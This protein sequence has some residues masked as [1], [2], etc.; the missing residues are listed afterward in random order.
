MLTFIVRR[1]IASFFIVIGA[2]FIAYMLVSYAGN[3]LTVAYGIQQP[4][5]RA[6]KI[7]Q[8][9]ADLHLNVNPVFRFFIWLK[10]VLACFIGRCDF[11]MTIDGRSVTEDLGNAVL[12]SLRL[13]TAATVAAILIGVSIGIITALRQYSGLDYTVTFLAFLFFSL[14]VFWFGV[15]LKDAVGIQF[16]DFLQKD[17]GAFSWAAIFIVSLVV[18]V[19]AYALFGGEL[20][21]R[22]LTALIAAVVTFGVMYYI[23]VTNWLLD[24]SLGIVM[25]ALI[26]VALGL[27]ITQLTA[28]V[29]NRKALYTSMTTV[30]VGV[31]L[32]Y[33]L[34]YYFYSDFNF[35]KL[36]LLF[37]IA[38]GV[39][40]V[41]GYL[42][43]GDD[44]GLSARTGAFTAVATSVVIFTDRMMRAWHA[45]MANPAINGRPIKLTL[46]GTP[47]LKG[48]FWIQTT[49]VFTHLLL[50]TITLMLV[51]LATHSRF[52]RASMLEVLNQDY[53]RTARSKGLTERTVVMRHAFRNALIPVATVIAFDIAGLV[54]GAVLT[55]TV[56]GWKALG[57][58]FQDGLTNFD[59]NPVMATFLVAAVIAV[60][61]NL[62]ADIAYGALDPR[63]RVKA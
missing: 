10:G 16:N 25:I 29:R 45:Y 59:P 9:T 19:V 22:L 52:A 12:I 37:V 2:S 60:L 14:P 18:G 48:D 32:W 49:D 53:I 54:G 15:L 43:G 27:G 57:K 58:M 55:E 36:M 33:P 28:G 3:P 24:P 11:G 34:Q 35:W 31:A 30:G 46:P 8:I 7:A 23:T 51:S 42:W 1:I 61:A 26:S 44:R 13:I 63:I 38:I 17:D 40:I 6:Q 39:G 20:K 62:L 56:F 21:R 5:A 47:L 4:E 41:V 50:P